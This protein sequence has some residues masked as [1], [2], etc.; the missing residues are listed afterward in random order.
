MKLPPSVCVFGVGGV[1]GGRCG[2]GGVRGVCRRGVCVC[3]C[4]CVGVCV[5]VWV[6]GYGGGGG[7]MEGG[8]CSTSPW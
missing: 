8:Q 2:E 3:V 5:W 7:G 6:C 4:G 1:V